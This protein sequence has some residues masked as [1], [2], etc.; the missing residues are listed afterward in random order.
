MTDQN[1]GSGSLLISAL[2]GAA[3]GAAGTGLIATFNKNFNFL[4]FLD[5]IESTA[6]TSGMIF[7]VLLGAEFFNSFIALSQLPN[8]LAELTVKHQLTPMIVVASILILYLFLGCLMDS[9]AMILLTIPV[10]F[11]LVMSLDFGMS[12]EETAIWFGILTLITVEVGLIT[13]PVGLNV[14]IIN[15]MA[16]DV[17]ISETFKGVLPF[18]LSD[19]IRVTLLFVFPSITLIMLKVFY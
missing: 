2:T 13:P 18:L 10:F 6:I 15:K 5:V 14:F 19:I 16:G 1:G 8:I 4:S 11:P 7:L 17:K 3:I 9:L 12:P